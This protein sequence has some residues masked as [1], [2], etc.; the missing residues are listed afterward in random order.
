MHGAPFAQHRPRQQLDRGRPRRP[1]ARR[2]PRDRVRL[3]VRH[4]HGEVHGHRLPRRRGSGPHAVVVVATVRALCMHGGGGLE[5][6]ATQTEAC[7]LIEIGCENLAKHVENVRE[8][9][10][11]PVVAV[12]RRPEDSDD[13][14]ALVKRLA[15]EAGAARGGPQR[16][17][18]RRPGRRRPGRGGGRG[19]R[20]ADRLPA[21]VPDDAPFKKKIEAIA[22]RIYGADGVDFAPLAIERLKQ[23]RGAGTRRVPDL[24]G[25]DAPLAVRRPEPEGPPARLPHPGPRR[26]RLHR[27]RLPGAAVRR[28]PADAGPR[29]A[30][31]RASTS[32]STRTARSSGC[33]ERRVGGGPDPRNRSGVT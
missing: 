14:V 24:H 25:E 7:R 20:P 21:P 29:Q 19:V 16:L 11:E 17:R 15:V 13:E 27:R 6:P 26:A 5:K 30:G 10:I 18:R 33:S 1:E 31:R 28:H 9:G 12:N 2:V 23:L 8:F 32:T 3:R 4:G 22:T